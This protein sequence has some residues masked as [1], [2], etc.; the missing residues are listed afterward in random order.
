[1]RK[2]SLVL[3]AL[4]IAGCSV[5]P[6]GSIFNPG[7][8][9]LEPKVL[10]ITETSETT[11]ATVGLR[12][13]DVLNA[14]SYEIVKKNSDGQSKVFTTDAKEYTDRDI[15]LEKTYTYTLRALDGNNMQLTVSSPIEVKPLTSG[16]DK[17]ALSTSTL[18]VESAQ[19]DLTW[20]AVTGASWYFIEVRD[21]AD[22]KQIYGAFANTNTWK[23]GSASYNKSLSL[24]GFNQIQNI[25]L[26]R[27]SS[28]NWTVTA[29]KADKEKLE[30]ATAIAK[31]TSDEGIIVY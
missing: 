29:L 14:K 18:T 7:N 3:P 21:R 10:A 17:P 4:L 22:N 26:K 1:M 19:P 15:N 25:G 20:N 23:L 16:L 11:T 27:G 31:R 24:P 6:A 28:Y 12:W 30:E 2:L 8:T 9:K 5:F 13:N